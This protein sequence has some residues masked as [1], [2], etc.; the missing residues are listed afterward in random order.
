MY[1]ALSSP[2]KSSEQVKKCKTEMIQAD[3]DVLQ[4]NDAKENA[5]ISPRAPKAAH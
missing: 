5:M 4:D 2:V 3:G 1:L